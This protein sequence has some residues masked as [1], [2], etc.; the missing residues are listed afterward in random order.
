MFELV[1]TTYLL[2]KMYLY[3]V[4]DIENVW[5]RN[6]LTC[7]IHFTKIGDSC[8]SVISIEKRV[9]HGSIFVTLLLL[10]FIK[11][12]KQLISGPPILFVC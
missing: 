2:R 7:I 9:P 5:I 10:M 12:S 8:S 4:R 1:N 6:N 11:R 3:G